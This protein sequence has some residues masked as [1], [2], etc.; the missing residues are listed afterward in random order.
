MQSDAGPIHRG[1]ADEAAG[2]F[3]SVESFAVVEGYDPSAETAGRGDSERFQRIES[4]SRFCRR[5]ESSEGG[6][7]PGH[8]RAYRRGATKV[9]P[10]YVPGI[11][12]STDTP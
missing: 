9:T 8:A 5:P 12:I 2:N 11:S 10:A 7:V 3:A 6:L 4:L 1:K